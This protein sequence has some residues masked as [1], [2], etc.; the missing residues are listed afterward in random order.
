[1]KQ[2]LLFILICIAAANSMAQGIARTVADSV[3]IED[4]FADALADTNTADKY[5]R[6]QVRLPA[7]AQGNMDDFVVRHFKLDRRIHFGTCRLYLHFNDK[8]IIDTAPIVTQS[9]TKDFDEEIIRIVKLMP[10][11]LPAQ[12]ADGKI[13]DLWT[14][15]TFKV[16]R[17]EN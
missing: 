4:I 1:M 7:F 6:V 15:V 3:Y 16:E 5:V 10:A 11:W 2:A 17:E 14:N 8:G 9:N 12:W 13:V